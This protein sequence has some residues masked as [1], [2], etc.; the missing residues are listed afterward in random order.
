MKGKHVKHQKHTIL[1]VPLVFDREENEKTRKNAHTDIS[2]CLVKI[3]SKE[4]MSNIS[5]RPPY[6]FVSLMFGR[7]GELEKGGWAVVVLC[8]VVV[9]SI[10]TLPSC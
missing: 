2:T 3:V 6:E 1:G 5:E 4:N 8:R 7:K 9:V 10:A